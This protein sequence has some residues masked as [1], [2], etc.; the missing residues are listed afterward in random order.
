HFKD[1]KNGS[2]KM[3][4]FYAK[5]ARGLMARFIIE[6]D[7]EKEED[8]QAF[9]SDGYNFNTGLSKPQQPVFTRG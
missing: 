2:Y 9:D 6:N 4:S 3:I 8:L 1:M 5:R 7:I